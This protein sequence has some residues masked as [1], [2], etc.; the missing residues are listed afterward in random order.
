MHCIDAEFYRQ[1]RRLLHVNVGKSYRFMTSLQLHSFRYY[2]SFESHSHTVTGEGTTFLEARRSAMKKATDWLSTIVD[3][4]CTH[5]SYQTFARNISEE[6]TIFV[7]PGHCP[8]GWFDEAQLL[9]IDFEGTPPCMIQIACFS[10]IVIE[11][12]H[13]EWVQT[14]LKD[15]KHT[16]AVFGQHELRLV[17]NGWDLQAHVAHERPQVHPKQEWSLVDAFT[18]ICKSNLR[19]K[20]D[21][22]IHRRVNWRA[23]ANQSS[24]FT[25]EA[26]EYAACDAW[27]TLC[28]ANTLLC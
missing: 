24:H 12:I 28:I 17:S 20:K 7:F 26:I 19:L 15:P 5:I 2:L 27:I 6:H 14:I 10:G 18:L 16:H 22:T 8:S 13:A 11:N 4:G 3:E 23:I 21:K 1:L 9:G 25:N